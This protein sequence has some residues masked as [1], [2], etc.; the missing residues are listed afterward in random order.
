MENKS[1]KWGKLVFKLALYGVYLAIA[2]TLL[3]IID[4]LFELELIKNE[5]YLFSNE[6]LFL[7]AEINQGG[8]ELNGSNG[9]LLFTML[10]L[11]IGLILTTFII[12]GLIKII[13]SVK[14]KASFAKTNEMELKRIGAIFIGLFILNTLS[15]YPTDTNGFTFKLDFE[16]YYILCSLI[17]YILAAVF[18]E[19]NEL[20]EEN[21]LTI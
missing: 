10:R 13:H 3:L 15:I 18:K 6:G 12:N 21:K 14:E 11:I 9:L 20:E 2:F 19:G 8:E 7:Q 1:L 16:I 17:A 5:H 4:V